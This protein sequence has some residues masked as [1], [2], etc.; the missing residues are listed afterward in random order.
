MITVSARI[1]LPSFMTSPEAR[2]VFA[3]FEERQILYVGGCVRDCILGKEIGD[4]DLATTLLPDDVSR[5]L[6]KAGI[7]ALPTGIEHGT[8][9][10]VK[11]K[12]PF[13]IT[14]L[15]R[16]VETDGRRAVV[17]FTDDWAEDAARRDFTI[18][19]LLCDLLGNVYDPT[20][21]GISDLHAG[22]VRFV[23]DADTRIREDYLRILRFFRFFAFY[24]KGASDK[25]ALAACR[26]HAAKI[27][28]L[29]RERITQE[30]LKL[31][32]APRVI[33]SLGLMKEN[34]ILPALFL[35]GGDWDALTRLVKNEDVPNVAARFVLLGAGTDAAQK[36]LDKVL[37]L[38]NA[39]RAAIQNIHAAAKTLKAPDDHALRVLLYRYGREVALAAFGVFCARKALPFAVR[40]KGLAFLKTEIIPVFPVTGKDLLRA[41]I[42]QGPEMGK[43]LKRLETAWIK[44]G[45]QADKSFLLEKI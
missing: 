35:R 15:R 16:D 3:V 25:K 44:N 4:L 20:G 43:I 28:T 27:K 30:T 6:K 8:V 45:F 32:T 33:E 13:Q 34:N 41:G 22:R 18:N 26:L 36:K 17:A 12:I 14:T 31:L 39:L 1:K 2:A 23:G 9:T 24:G 40:R 42:G 19:T 37:I 7:K 38:P 11:N 5:R 21:Q 10:A 29:S